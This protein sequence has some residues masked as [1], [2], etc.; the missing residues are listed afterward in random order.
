[1][2]GTTDFIFGEATA[3]FRDCEIRPKA[4]SFITAASTPSNQ[5]FG[6]VF[7]RCNLTASD[8]VNEVYLGRPWR[9][10]A[11][12]VW[13]N[14]E[15]GDH[16]IPAGW[17]NWNN[18]E[19]E[20]TVFYAEYNSSGSGANPSARVAW[21]HQLTVKEERNYTLKRIFGTWDVSSPRMT[22]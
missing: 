16:I 7:L 22:R 12:T 8:S 20:K 11:R 4:N 3:V 19:N 18:I 15:L 13:V 1:V 9:K 21:S 17:D 5:R 2:E 10:Y 14:C 6:L